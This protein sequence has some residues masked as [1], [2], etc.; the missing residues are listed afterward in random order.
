MKLA[1]A[2]PTRSSS[3]LSGIVAR[4]GNL[5]ERTADMY[6][7][8]QDLSGD[9][10]E[11][12]AEAFEDKTL[13]PRRNPDMQQVNTVVHKTVKSRAIQRAFND[14]H[15]AVKEMC[16]DYTSL[17]GDYDSVPDEQRDDYESGLD[18]ALEK[19]LEP[20]D[21]HI[22]ANFYGTM[23][24]DSRL[25]ESLAVH[26]W[27]Q[28]AAKEVFKEMTYGRTPAQVLSNAGITQEMMQ[29]ALDR[30]STEQETTMDEINTLDDV[31]AQIAATVGKGYDVMAMDENVTAAQD[32]DP[33]TANAAGARLGLK[34][35]AVQVLQF[36]FIEHGTD[37][38]D[39]LIGKVD[40]ALE[41]EKPKSKPKRTRAKKDDSP[42]PADAV[43]TTVMETI[44]NHSSAKDNDVAE[45]VL[46]VS[47]GTFNSYVKGKS[48]FVPEGEQINE[49]RKLLIHDLNPLAAALAELDGTEPTVFH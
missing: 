41:A 16:D 39:V 6:T 15:T 24:I 7:Y 49:L 2:P 47:R 13:A 19:C 33:V 32:D 17:N 35:A 9:P 11:V 37:L 21:A 48:H 20:W 3:F 10:G 45:G 43:S 18:D 36:G 4:V 34:P 42:P 44:K 31:A 12:I 23:T 5:P 40:A 26:K 22:S 46:N 38:T 8:I 30:N 1:L 14:I 28:A 29:S 25:W 27:C